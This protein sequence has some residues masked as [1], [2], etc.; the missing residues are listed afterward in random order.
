M[1]ARHPLLD[2]R[3]RFEHALIA[4]GI[5]HHGRPRLGRDRPRPAAGE[6]RRV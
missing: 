6:G 3:G 1:D 5:P 4:T 2:G